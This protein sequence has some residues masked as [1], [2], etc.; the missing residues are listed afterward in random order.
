MSCT[1]P[2]VFAGSHPT[3][4]RNWNPEC[5]EHGA[6]SE[7]WNSEEQQKKREV[8]IVRSREL[9]QRA[10]EQRQRRKP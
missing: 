5:A 6:E 7:W 9:Q 8:E 10:R 1:C 2:E 4:T 3:G